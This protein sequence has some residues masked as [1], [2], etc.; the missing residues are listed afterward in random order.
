MAETS[1]GGWVRLAAS[2]AAS[3]RPWASCSGAASAGRGVAPS[4]TRLS[5]S[6]TGI[7]AATASPLRAIVAGLAA[8]FF[9]ELDALDAHATFHALHHVV[10]GQAG[11]RNRGERLH[12]DAGLAGDLHG[13][14]HHQA[15]LLAVGVDI[16]GDLRDRQGMAE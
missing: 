11:D 9:Q 13:R 3:T 15:R 2:S 14:A 7:S 16:D 12:L 1:S 6:A 10:D 8:G 4:S 5:A